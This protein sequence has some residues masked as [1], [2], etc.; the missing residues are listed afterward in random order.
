MLGLPRLNSPEPEASGQATRAELLLA[1]VA[2]P[3]PGKR[4][5]QD[6]V[7]VEDAQQEGPEAL[8]RKLKKLDPDLRHEEYLHRTVDGETLWDVEAMAEDLMLTQRYSAESLEAALQSI[9]D[10]MRLLV[11]SRPKPTGAVV[12]VPGALL[13]G[14]ANCAREPAALQR[15]GVK[16]IVNCSPQTVKTGKEFYGPGV[17]YM[18]LWEDDLLDYCVLQDFE[19]VWRFA[20][21]G[22]AC[23]LHCEQGVNRS[24]TLVAA[25]HMKM[26]SQEGWTTQLSPEDALRSSWHHIADRKARVLTNPSFQRQLLL[27]ARLGFRWFP[28]LA[29]VWRTP[30]ERRMARFRSLAEQVGHRIVCAT[31]EVPLQRRW[32]SVVYIRDGTMRGEMKMAEGFDL[33][34]AAA[35]KSAR[36]RIRNYAVR[37]MPKLARVESPPRDPASVLAPR[38]TAVTLR[39]GN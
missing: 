28:S 8:R 38:T 34:S 25:I 14:D 18:E 39:A 15:L 26:R 27:F 17:E 11:N 36:H 22:G 32:R 3:A 33:S 37:S 12:I 24:G 19:A 31:P 6:V 10:E 7:D 5:G 30:K 2:P 29:G 21:A 4:R 23:L 16:R 1:A 20:V 13:L 35:L 9:R